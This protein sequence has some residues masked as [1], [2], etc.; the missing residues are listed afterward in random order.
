MILIIDKFNSNINNYSIEFSQL[1]LIFL[2]VVM[3]F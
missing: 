3:F 2:F 1:S